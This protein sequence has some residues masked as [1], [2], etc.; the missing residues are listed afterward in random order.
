MPGRSSVAL[1]LLI[2]SQGREPAESPSNKLD[3]NHKSQTTARRSDAWND[4]PAA[5][6]HE[7]HWV[8]ELSQQKLS[9]NV[10]RQN[11]Q[12]RRGVNNNTPLKLT[13]TVNCGRYEFS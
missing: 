10:R 1:T 13:R 3:A 12:S 6:R 9:I 8:N 11:G 4:P 7:A 5:G 2:N